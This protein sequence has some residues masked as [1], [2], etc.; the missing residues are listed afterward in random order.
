M[1]LKDLF[2]KPENEPKKTGNKQ[3]VNDN[4]RDN[5]RNTNSSP[6]YNAPSRPEP[7]PAP[8]PQEPVSSID[9]DSIIPDS[10]PEQE[11]TDSPITEV[12]NVKKKRLWETL[13][14]RNLPGPDMLELKSYSASLESM[15]LSL[16]KRYEAA[17]KMLKAQYPDFTKEKLLKSIDTYISFVN[18]EIESGRMQYAEK[19]KQT[20]GEQQKRL[21]NMIKDNQQVEK[22]LEELQKRNKELTNEIEKLKV[23]VT[24]ATKEIAHDEQVFINSANSVICDLMTDKKEMSN[25]NVE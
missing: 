24:A 9:M 10:T 8:A 1:S 18:E 6:S 16:D 14:K 3:P 15:G 12:N 13:I 2:I 23:E 21:E 17:F 5:A 7:E 25:I 11:A 19:R 20:V 22:Q 4:A